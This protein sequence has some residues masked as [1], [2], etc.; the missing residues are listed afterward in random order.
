MHSNVQK[1]I[2]SILFNAETLLISQ[3]EGN[4]MRF[5]FFCILFHNKQNYVN[6]YDSRMET[7]LR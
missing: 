1:V 5:Y 3:N 4:N 7:L 2:E 6:L